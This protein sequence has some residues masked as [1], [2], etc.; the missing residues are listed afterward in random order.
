MKKYHKVS[1]SLL[2]ILLVTAVSLQLYSVRPKQDL[3]AASN[4]A[5]FSVSPSSGGFPLGSTASFSIFVSLDNNFNA[6]TADFYYNKDVFRYVNTTFSPSFPQGRGANQSSNGYGSYIKITGSRS[7][8]NIRGKHALATLH[9]S[10]RSVGNTYGNFGT[11]SAVLYPTKNYTTSAQ[12]GSFSVY[13][14]APPKPPT[15][16]PTNPAPPKPPT[17]A[18]TNPAPPKPPTP[19]PTNPATPAQPVTNQISSS[20]QNPNPGSTKTPS[21]SKTAPRVTYKPR[22]TTVVPSASKPSESGLMISD[23]LIS[24]KEYRT[25]LLTWKTNRP[26]TTKVNYGTN[27]DDLRFEQKN[28]TKTVD[29]SL[30]LDSKNLKAGSRYY[31]RITSNDDKGPVT[32]DGDFYTKFIPVIIKVT[33]ESEAP[34][35]D[36]SVNSGDTGGYTNEKGEA[37][38]DLPEGD[39][40]IYAEKDDLQRELSTTIEL[41]LADSGESQRITMSLSPNSAPVAQDDDKKRPPIALI[42]TAIFITLAVGFSGF[43][44]FMRRRNSRSY[45]N[46]DPL[47]AD[48]YVQH[49]IPS[50]TSPGSQ[51]TTLR[52]GTPP[53]IVTA[54][55][56][57]TPIE[58]PTL[59]KYSSLPEMVGRYGTQA[60]T[61]PP[62]DIPVIPQPDST[63]PPQESPSLPPQQQIQQLP[64]QPL[65]TLPPPQQPII[66]PLSQQPPH[67]TSLKDMVKVNQPD[68]SGESAAPVNDLPI[69]PSSSPNQKIS[70]QGNPTNDG[71]SDGSL[72]IHH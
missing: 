18:P 43:I 46:G 66:Q 14:P 15:P 72:T 41:P 67:H 23:F 7:G 4:T 32:I 37:L 42:V 56:N 49:T 19:A 11:T 6:A 47:E 16:A 48:N 13:K 28:D 53:H 55:P 39:V 26:S 34:L 36:V 22:V 35:A 10:M 57:Y 63:T 9:F 70:E 68:T 8:G 59:K 24:K 52:H 12:N 40:V 51:P 3:I 65:Q 5:S 31:V 71:L 29:H 62:T 27:K 1:I 38:L 30:Q 45:S 20:N 33:D 44:F 58:N 64:Q 21:K 69:A 25:A 2:A 61:P 54:E 17:T 60:T 50:T